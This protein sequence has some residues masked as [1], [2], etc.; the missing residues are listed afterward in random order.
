MK[1]TSINSR[2]VLFVGML[3][4][5]WGLYL[6]AF[7]EVYQWADFFKG[8]HTDFLTRLEFTYGEH[9]SC[10][11]IYSAVGFILLNLTLSLVL[12]TY[13]LSLTGSTLNKYFTWLIAHV[14]VVGAGFL[15]TTTIWPLM[16]IM[17]TLSLAIAYVRYILLEI[18]VSQRSFGF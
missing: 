14:F 13:F 18:K 7:R 12:R 10:L 6:Y 2:I 11:V 1:G 17:I 4:V 5:S 15:L 3:V 9:P 16:L 8:K